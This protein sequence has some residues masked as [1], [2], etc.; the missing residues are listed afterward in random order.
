M[1]VRMKKSG[2]VTSRS[3]DPRG[4]PRLLVSIIMMKMRIW[5]HLHLSGIITLGSTI[6]RDNMVASGMLGVGL[7]EPG[8]TSI[9]FR[10][11]LNTMMIKIRT[12]QHPHLSGT[13]PILFRGGPKNLSGTTPTLFRGPLNIMM[14][15]IR[16][17]QHP[18]LSGTTPARH[19]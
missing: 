10:G 8:T 17:W 18:H 15:K 2:F 13:T 6:T 9:L 3:W 12:W 11:A 7:L 1:V 19:W 4:P 14:M 5:Q 16:T